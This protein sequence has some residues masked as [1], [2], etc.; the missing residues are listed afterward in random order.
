MQDQRPMTAETMAIVLRGGHHD[1]LAAEE[2]LG[3]SLLYIPRM[4][5]RVRPSGRSRRTVVRVLH[6]WPGYCFLRD[7]GSRQ[8]QERLSLL[9]G[10]HRLYHMMET[11]VTRIP[12][13][14]LLPSRDLEQLS[15][16][17]ASEPD[18][19]VPPPVLHTPGSRVRVD[20]GSWGHMEGT[21]AEADIH[22]VL[23]MVDGSS[24]FSRIRADS[25]RCTVL[26]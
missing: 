5:V 8:T 19:S 18:V 2:Q 9:T 25:A 21:V 22:S 26:P 14:E 7:D 17:R 23:V 24:A 1:L 11:C 13:S 15:H 20:C 6:Q 10:R 12:V 16:L 4:T 3:R